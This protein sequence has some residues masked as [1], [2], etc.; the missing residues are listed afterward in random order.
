[1]LTSI[2][3]GYAPMPALKVKNE[4]PVTEIEYVIKEVWKK[5]LLTIKGDYK[6]E[7]TGLGLILFS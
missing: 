4:F 1:M 2:I 3:L 5:Y 6:W 7:N